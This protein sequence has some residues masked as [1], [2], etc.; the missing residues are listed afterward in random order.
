MQPITFIN[1]SEPALNG[2]NMNLLQSNVELYC[3]DSGPSF[4]QIIG[5]F[6]KPLFKL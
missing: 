6:S 5:L 1:N 3:T 2:P 4:P